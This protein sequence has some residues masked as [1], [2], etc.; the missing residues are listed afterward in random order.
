MVGLDFGYGTYALLGSYWEEKEG[1]DQG[2]NLFE[3][4]PR[5][6]YILNPKN[7]RSKTYISAEFFY[8]NHKDIFINTTQDLKLNRYI[9]TNSGYI[10]YD[11]ANFYRQKYGV[12]FVFGM[13]V[14]FFKNFGVNFNI[15]LGIRNRKITYKN[16][17]NAQEF[18]PQENES[19][20]VP[21]HLAVTGNAIGANVSLN[22]KLYYK[23]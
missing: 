13:L 10:M 7:N 5:I 4:R 2:Y 15:G 11:Q 19:L 12:N 9:N 21:L 6:N 1:L 3:I 14:D 22:L 23:F 8:I 20:V 18:T 16:I 17:I